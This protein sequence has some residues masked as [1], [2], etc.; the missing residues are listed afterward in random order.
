LFQ[1]VSTETSWNNC[2]F[3][4]VRVDC[5]D[6]T[7]KNERFLNVNSFVDIQFRPYFSLILNKHPNWL[8]HINTYCC[9]LEWTKMIFIIKHNILWHARLIFYFFSFH[10]SV[11]KK[12]KSGNLVVKADISQMEWNG[13]FGNHQ[14][15]PNNKPSYFI[16]YPESHQSN[17]PL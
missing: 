17:I 8:R 5:Q 16:H 9:Q 2:S 3:Q 12:V 14:T 10:F 7:R 1:K 4:K 11:F 15:I 6:K 13:L